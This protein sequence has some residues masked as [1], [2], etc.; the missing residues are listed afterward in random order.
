[1]ESRELNWFGKTKN[2]L[3]ENRY[4]KYMGKV[5]EMTKMYEE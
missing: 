4:K 3:E 2:E 5:W 1:L